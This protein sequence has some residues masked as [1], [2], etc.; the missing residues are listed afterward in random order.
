[1][2][3]RPFLTDTALALGLGLTRFNN[4]PLENH[5]FSFATHCVFFIKLRPGLCCSFCITYGSLL[6]A[7]MS[8]NHEK[9]IMLDHS[10][11]KQ[12]RP[13]AATQFGE[14][15]AHAQTAAARHSCV[16]FL[17]CAFRQHTAPNSKCYGNQDFYKNKGIL[18]LNLNK[19]IHKIFLRSFLYFFLINMF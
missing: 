8:T 11:H 12:W 19:N 9:K 17:L 5:H 10:I 15:S 2:N 6:S 3:T 7:K 4:L 14:Q 1:M 16:P 18:F 13:F